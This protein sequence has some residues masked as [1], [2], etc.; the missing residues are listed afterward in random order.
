MPVTRTFLCRV[1]FVVVALGMLGLTWSGVNGGVDQWG[2]SRTPG[3]L[4]QTLMQ[5]AFALFA[6]LSLVTMIWCRRWNRLMG[7]GLTVSLGLAGGLASVFWGGTSVA[8]GVVG[9]LASALIGFGIAWLARVAAW[10]RGGAKSR[11]SW[12][13]TRRGPGP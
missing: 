5:F 11:R 1:L 2:Q 7:M 13:T 8:V 9:A 3:Q 10:R 4:A 12:G 6:L